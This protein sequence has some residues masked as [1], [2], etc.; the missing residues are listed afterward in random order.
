MCCSTSNMVGPLR[1]PKDCTV[2]VT[3]PGG[4]ASCFSSRRVTPSGWSVPAAV[5]VVGVLIF[6]SSHAILSLSSRSRCANSFPTSLRAHR[7]PRSAHYRR[8][9]RVAAVEVIDGRGEH[10][11]SPWRRDEVVVLENRG[12]ELE[13][14]RFRGLRE[15]QPAR[16]P[17]KRLRLG[18]FPG[19]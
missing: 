17:Q 14:V 1:A 2:R 3:G 7:L 8:V 5:I 6:H 16:C 15:D 9:G 4:S 11:R 13:V 19:E 18:V 10:V 12:G